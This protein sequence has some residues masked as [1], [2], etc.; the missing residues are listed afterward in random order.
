[1]NV[2]MVF[3]K[4]LRVDFMHLGID[5]SNIR[6]GG[7][8]THIVQLL[9][10]A[11]PLD[12]GISHVTIWCSKN[13]AEKLPRKSWLTVRVEHWLDRSLIMRLFWQQFI[14][15]KRLLKNLC[16]I[17][18]SPG[19]TLPLFCSV[20]TVTICQ[21]MLPFESSQAKLFG[22]FS[23]MRLKM[24][25]LRYSQ[26]RSFK[27]ADGVIFLTEYAKNEVFKFLGG[28]SGQHSTIPHGIERR[29]FQKPK[30]QID[31][32]EFDA[33][34]PFR[35][36]YVSIMMPYKHQIEVAQAVYELKSEGFFIE[37][38]F[39]GSVYKKYYDK[40][41]NIKQT[42]DLK[43]EFIHYLGEKSFEQLHSLYQDADFFIFAS[44]CENLPNILVESMASGL[45]IASSNMG[46]MLE[47]L[48][49]AA[50]YF[51]PYNVKS[52][53]E[54]IKLANKN[55]VLRTSLS[56][57]A[58]HR[59]QNYSWNSTAKQTLKFISELGCKN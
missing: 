30:K 32:I 9:R 49:D 51:D 38:N 40:F 37:V 18:F 41:N 59:A 21:N 33:N 58:W 42:L 44:S 11:E 14:L 55:A 46:P 23:F 39:V 53:K 35:L 15:P 57:A 52:I 2:G 34:R 3:L 48:G 22:R 16:N 1:M 36:L 45:P 4:C 10:E 8:V 56:N 31:F 50:I 19:G 12:F 29:F 24:F 27:R 5:A 20:P 54:A 43:D 47:V 28:I 25:F 6:Q 13:L 26:G 7:G 17:L